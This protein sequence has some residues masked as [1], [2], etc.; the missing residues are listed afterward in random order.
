[1][2]DEA[3]R[4]LLGLR[5]RLR[6]FERWSEQQARDAGL[7]PAHHQLL[8][9]IRGHDDPRGPTIGEVADYL[10]LRH[11]SVVGLI[12]RAIVARLVTRTRDDQDHRVVRLHLTAE[13]AER[14]EALSA[15]H[16]EEL[17]RLGPLRS[18]ASGELGPRP[19][20]QAYRGNAALPGKGI[21]S[22]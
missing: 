3:Y 13:G 1:M 8:L 6:Q 11:H 20:S 2:S 4:R 15:L 10:Q 18:G 22:G 12:D 19:R 21:G 14:L 17:E 7:T 5:T 16:L 9:S